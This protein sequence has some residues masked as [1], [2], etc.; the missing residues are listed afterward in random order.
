MS[1]QLMPEDCL[2]YGDDCRGPVRF[3]MRPSDWKSFAR[4]DHH[5][6]Q[7]EQDR[8]NSMERYA[9]SDVAP[10]WFDP[11]YAGERWDDDY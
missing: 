4:C 10:G 5:Q 7:R 8:E 3:H 9:D 2:N 11:S 1:D 6:A